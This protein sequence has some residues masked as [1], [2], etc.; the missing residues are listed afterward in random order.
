MRG[1]EPRRDCF[2]NSTTRK[3]RTRVFRDLPSARADG[4]DAESTAPKENDGATNL[5]L[6]L[7]GFVTGVALVDGTSDVVTIRR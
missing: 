2:A 4:K 6:P 5:I 1:N 3:R 7:V